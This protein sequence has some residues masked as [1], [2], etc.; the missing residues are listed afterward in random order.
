MNR[1][2]EHQK[3]AIGVIVPPPFPGSYLYRG[4]SMDEVMDAV[5][6]QAAVYDEL[7]Y[8]GVF[9][10]NAHDVPAPPHAPV[11]T[12]A[13]MTAVT[14]AVH[15]AFPKLSVGVM[16]VW[17]GV[18]SLAA[19]DAA[20]A[21]FIRVEHAY[22]GAEMI[23]SGLAPAQCA[24]ITALRSRIRSKAAVLADVY[25]CHAVQLCP[26]PLQRAAFEA[27]RQCH[28]DGV[29]L[30]G[31]TPEESAA[32]ADQVRVQL[33]E[34]KL[35]LGNGSTGDNVYSLLRH[36]DG[37]CVG[38]WIKDGCTSNPINRDRAKFYIDEVRRAQEDMP[39]AGR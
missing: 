9:L 14:T 13:Y 20:G 31:A 12:V 5:L 24:E 32:L 15:R 36:F 3:C 4:A 19:A 33:P 35:F 34:A 30:S 38:T 23:P 27:V 16:M 18:A 39:Q 21:D 11:E 37:V 2:W 1:P 8:H 25:E 22:I 17:D 29:F 28:A 10:Q 26:K 7:G 6:E